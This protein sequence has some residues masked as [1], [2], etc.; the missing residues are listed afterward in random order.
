MPGDVAQGEKNGVQGAR[1]HATLA[2]ISA[3]P[4]PMVP[5]DRWSSFFGPRRPK[6]SAF[7]PFFTG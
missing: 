5:T 4:W 3:L 1:P 6:P 7:I 2:L